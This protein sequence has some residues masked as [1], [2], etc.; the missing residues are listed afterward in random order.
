MK[1]R[2]FGAVDVLIILVIAACIVG[3]V[4]RAVRLKNA[5]TEKY[6]SYRVQFTAQLDIKQLDAVRSGV[7]LSDK[8]NAQYTLLEGYWITEAEETATVSGEFLVRG[9]MTEK[10]FECGDGFY[11]KNDVV[12]LN[13]DGL[14]FE[15]VL[16]EFIGQ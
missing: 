9:R 3:I 4:S 12:K 2:S 5:E 14:D 15:A 13:G 7:K 8:N 6:G 1:K 16:T 10:G 11:F